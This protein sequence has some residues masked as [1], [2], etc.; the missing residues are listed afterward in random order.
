MSQAQV[1]R[2]S[3]LMERLTIG[4]SEEFAAELAA[5]MESHAY[6]NRSKVNRYDDIEVSTA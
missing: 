4:V 3:F 6:R 1:Q 5:F 2:G